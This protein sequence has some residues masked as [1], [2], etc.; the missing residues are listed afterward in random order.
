[1]LNTTGKASFKE[2][3]TSILKMIVQVI[4]QL[5]VAYTIQA[6]MGWISGS[7]IRLPGSRSGSFLSS[8][9]YDGGGYTGHGVY[10]PAGVVHRGEF[11]FTKEATSRIGVSNLYRMMRGYA[12][13]GMSATLPARRVSP[14]AV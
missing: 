9:G 8:A 2:F 12:P 1:L 3:T 10:E 6:A 14:L 13:A 11:V 5:I 7:A 4:N